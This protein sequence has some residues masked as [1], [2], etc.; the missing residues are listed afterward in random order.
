MLRVGI[1]ILAV[2]AFIAPAWLIY[3]GYEFVQVLPDQGWNL[4]LGRIVV[5][6]LVNLILTAMIAITAVIFLW[7]RLAS[8][9]SELQGWHT[10]RPE[11]EFSAADAVEGYTFDDYLAQEAQVFDEL[12]AFI[13]DS[14]ADHSHGTYSRYHKES[15][16]NPETIV[17]RNWNRSHVLQADNPIGGVLLVHGLSDAPYSLRSIGQRLHAEGYTVV[18]LRVPGHGTCPGALASIDWKDWT[19]AVQVAAKGLRDLL[20]AGRPLVLAGY[21]NG[22]SLAVNYA[23]SS[24]N[25]RSLPQIDAIMLFSPM[26]GINPLARISRLYHTVALVSRNKKAQWS[27]IEAEVDPF[28]FSSWPMNANVQAWTMTQVVEAQLAALDKSGRMSEMPPVLAMQSLVDSTVIVSKLITVLFDRLKSESSELFLFDI[29]RVD[30]LSNLFNRTFEQQIFPKLTKTDLPFCL[31]MLTNASADSRKV[32]VQTRDGES[33]IEQETEMVWP[34]TV[35]SLSHLAVPISPDDPIYGYQEATSKTGL[36][37]GSL[38][39]RAE[40]SALLM[41]N[42]L[43]VR[44]RNNPFYNFMEN[45]VVDWLNERVNGIG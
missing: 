32:K 37:L 38:S 6:I 23:I 36:P 17:D 1:G 29:D 3:E 27:S 2:C 19:A 12:D 21:S 43:F 16:C 33:W 10:D 26:I 41:S 18:W 13:A 40:P 25:D 22:G 8:S 14:W 20:P 9:L 44:C 11:S 15:I 30:N 39:L 5:L 45:H 28:K 7:V 42:S 31:R 4:H 35:V 34:R 24:I